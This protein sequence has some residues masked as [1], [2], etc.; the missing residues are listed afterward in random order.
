MLLSR[1]V[2]GVTATLTRLD[3]ARTGRRA[4]TQSAA[5]ARPDAS[6]GRARARRPLASEAAARGWNLSRTRED[7]AV[8]SRPFDHPPRHQGLLALG[9]FIWLPLVLWLLGSGPL[10][11]P[12]VAAVAAGL[13]GFFLPDLALHGEAETG[14]ATSAT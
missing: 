4:M 13:V 9:A 12:T 10:R 3:G 1:P 7:L 6:A 2:P 11:V 14:G 8:M 5:D